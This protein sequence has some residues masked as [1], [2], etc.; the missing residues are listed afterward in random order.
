MEWDFG[1]VVASFSL[2]VKG[3]QRYGIRQ[4]FSVPEPTEPAE[5]VQRG[6]VRPAST[7]GTVIMDL[8]ADQKTTA[9]V[10]WTDEVG[11]DTS[12]PDGASVSYASSDTSIV[13]VND[14]GDGTAEFVAVG[15]LGSAVASVQA[16]D[17]QGTTLTG[18]ETINVVAGHAERV[19]LTFSEP[20]EATPDDI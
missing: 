8:G 19:R 18:E 3:R 13:A 16:S 6:A 7:K 11:N 2:R 12:T 1:D 17:G 15:P 9:S 10:Q 5:R 14:L 20:T 4:R